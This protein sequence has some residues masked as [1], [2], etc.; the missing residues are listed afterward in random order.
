MA[1]QKQSTQLQNTANPLLTLPGYSNGSDL[2]IPR[3]SMK[4]TRPW[5]RRRAGIIGIV[6]VLLVVLAAGLLYTQLKQQPPPSYQYG[7]VTQGDLALT[8]DATGPLQSPATYNLVAAT[9]GI[10]KKIDVNLGQKVTRG[11]V[12]AELDKTVLQDAVNQA[13]ATVNADQDALFNTEVSTGW[14]VTAAV[15]QAEDTLKIAQ[16]QLAAARHN[17]DGATLRAPHAGVVTVINGT[18]GGTPGVPLNGSSS[19]SGGNYF[20]QIVDLSSLQIVAN[21][22]E[23][24]TANLKVGDPVLFTIDAYGDRQFKGVVEA[25]SSNGV[26]S[27]NVVSYPVIIDVDTKSLQGANLLPGMTAAV[28]ITVLQH[29]NALIIPASAISF[30]R[31]VSSG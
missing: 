15:T 4:P 8:I 23:S 19:A 9:S 24:D 3:N 31:T 26:T 25:I 27:S 29:S 7:Q 20:I 5:W 28:T 6:L 21:V 14:V 17:L 2:S 18:V 16:A 12:L 13:Q 1:Q 11:Q 10:I 22:N 30:A